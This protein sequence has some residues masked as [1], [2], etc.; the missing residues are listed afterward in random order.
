MPTLTELTEAFLTSLPEPERRRATLQSYHRSL[1]RFVAWLKETTHLNDPGLAELTAERAHAFTRWLSR[2]R[3]PDGQVLSGAAQNYH[4]SALRSFLTYLRSQ[5]EQVLEPGAVHLKRLTREAVSVLSADEAERLL[6]APSMTTEAALVQLRDR[7]LLALLLAT[8]LKTAEA[9]ALTRDQLSAPDKLS[10]SPRRSRSLL[11]QLSEDCVISLQAYLNARAD[12]SPSLFVRHDRAGSGSN[13]PLTPRSVQRILERYR[14]AANIS[15]RLT[16]GTLRHTFAAML[17]RR[18]LEPAQVSQTLG[19]QSVGTLKLYHY[20]TASAPQGV[21][22][23][24][25]T[26]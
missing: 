19:H 15:G 12:S 3:K 1:R 14:R 22:H 8:G 21:D 20:L 18:G 24:R 16:P 26:A 2:Y 5:G 4:L 23:E 6:Q 10:L 13:Q 11:L 17:L 9:A 7:A 25:K